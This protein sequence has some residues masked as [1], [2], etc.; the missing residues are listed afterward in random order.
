MVLRLRGAA[1]IPLGAGSPTR[2]NTVEALAAPFRSG[3]SNK[4][5][6]HARRP[7]RVSDFAICISDAHGTGARTGPA[8]GYGRSARAAQSPPSP[9]PYAGGAGDVWRRGPVGA[10]S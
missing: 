10:V 6:E 7:A 1:T 8:H 4:S 5:G 3:P 9:D 2:Q